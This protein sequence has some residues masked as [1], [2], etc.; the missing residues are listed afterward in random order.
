MFD[1]FGREEK[2]KR[3]ITPGQKKAFISAV[4]S[5]CEKCGERDIAVLDL[6]HIKPVSE[7][8]SDTPSNLI[9]LCAS[10]HRRVHGGSLTTKE[11]RRIVSGRSKKVRGALAEWHRRRKK[12]QEDKKGAKDPFGFVEASR[13]GR[14]KKDPFSFE[15]LDISDILGTPKKK[16]SKEKSPFEIDIPEI[17]FDLFGNSGKRRRGKKKS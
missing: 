13:G 7:G 11:L 1:R 17:D 15:V 5:R 16:R 12:L 9:V 2:N 6:H 8:G 4:G 3:T 14:K 10:C